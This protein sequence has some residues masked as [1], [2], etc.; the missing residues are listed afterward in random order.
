MKL[1][2]KIL[3]IFTFVFT[4][5]SIAYSHE[6]ELHSWNSG[7]HNSNFTGNMSKNAMEICDNQWG[8]SWLSTVYKNEIHDGAWD[9]DE[10]PQYIAHGY[11]PITGTTGGTFSGG[12]TTL[13]WAAEKWAEMESAFN[14]GQYI[15]GDG[16]G[17][18]HYLGRCCHLLQDMTT[19][20]HIHPQDITGLPYDLINPKHQAF[21]NSEL[22]AFKDTNWSAT[23]ALYLPTDSLDTIPKSTEKLDIFSADRLKSKTFTNNAIKSFIEQVARITYFRSTFWGEVLFATEDNDGSATSATTTSTTFSDGTVGSKDNI[24]HKMFGVGNIRYI[25]TWNND[26]FDITDQ[27]GGHFTWRSSSDGDDD[28]W[29]P[30]AEETQDGHFTS[31]GDPTDTGVRTTGRFHFT[32]AYNVNPLKYPD[33]STFTDSS[34][35]FYMCK[36]AIEVGLS[37]NAALIGVGSRKTQTISFQSQNPTSGVWIN[38][39]NHTNLQTIIYSTSGSGSYELGTV[40]TITAPTAVSGN[41][42]L[43]WLKNGSQ[44]STDQQ[45]IVGVKNNDTY[46]AVYTTGSSHEKYVYGGCVTSL[47]IGAD[48][49]WPSISPTTQFNYL[50]DPDHLCLR[51][52]LN[53]AYKNGDRDPAIRV[54]CKFYIPNDPEYSDAGEYYGYWYWVD[55]PPASGYYYAIDPFLILPGELNTASGGRFYFEDWPGRW[56][57][58]VYINEG[59]GRGNEL[60]EE[61]YFD[62]LAQ[63]VATPTFSPDGGSHASALNV[64][65]NCSTSNAI[66]HY[67]TDGTIPTESSSQYTGPISVNSSKTL[68]AKSWKHHWFPSAVKS[69]NYNI[70]ST[71]S[72]N[73]SGAPSV[74][75]SSST[76]HGGVTNYTKAEDIGTSV[77]LQAPYYVG[78]GVSRARFNGWIGSVTSSNQS[79]TFVMNGNKSVTANYISD[80]ETYVISGYVLTSE[81][82]GIIGVTVTANN[83]GT[84]YTTQADGFYTLTVPYNWTGRVTH[85]NKIWYEFTPEYSDYSNVITNQSQNYKG[86]YICGA[87]DGTESNPYEI[88]TAQQFNYIGKF[89]DLWSKHFNLMADIDMFIYSGTKYNII[90]NT[91]TPFTGSFDGNGHIISNLTISTSSSCI[92]LFGF[93][94]SGGQIKNLGLDNICISGGYATGGLVGWNSGIIMSCYATGSVT[95][96]SSV[97]G[98]VGYGYDDG[99]IMSCYAT[100]SVSGSYAVGGLV[101]DNDGII[102][103]CYAT[104]TVIS[105]ACVGGIVGG[106]NN[107]PTRSITISCFWDMQTSGQTVSASGRGL[108]TEQMKMMSIYQNAGWADKGWVMNDGVD[109]PRLSWEDSSGLP[110]PLPLAIPLVGNGTAEDPYLVSTPQ[111]FALLSWHSEVLDKHIRLT[112]DLDMSGITLYPIGDFGYFNGIFDGNSCILSNVAISQTSSDYV[113]LFGC[114]RYGGDVRDLIIKNIRI[115]GHDHVGGLAGW[116]SGTITNCIVSGTTTGFD[117][118]GGLVGY[119]D[120]GFITSCSTS[121]TVVGSDFYAGGLVGYNNYGTINACSAIGTVGNYSNGESCYVGGLV[122]QNNES[123]LAYCYATG[124]VTAASPYPPRIGGLVGYN[125]HSIID[126]CYATGLVSIISRCGCCSCIDTWQCCTPGGLI[127]YEFSS[128]VSACFWDFQ[129]SNQA[130]SAGGIGKTTAEMKN[131]STFTDAGWDFT[132]A[133]GDVADWMMLREGEDYPRLAWQSVI[134]GDVAGEYGI[135]LVDF[136][137]LTRW[138]KNSDCQLNQDCDHIDLNQD[139]TVDI[140]D[141]IIVA[142]NWLQGT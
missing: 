123:V 138:W 139:G 130:S 126:A 142:D 52:E 99:T 102:I 131:L 32:T 127:G 56:T 71:L 42:F 1:S 96:S 77:N 140:I 51:I 117:S 26:Y 110:I 43:K 59:E 132:A 128:I 20:A 103:S 101:G 15:G 86:T 5:F 48:F 53:D 49:P 22:A 106:N 97:G 124:N 90:G 133:D 7:D 108:I 85:S 4:L 65:I 11:N 137:Y 112:A 21:E 92:G 8:A 125:Y 113:G 63:T 76:G 50:G 83:G 81:G 58:K 37:Y 17:A 64:T 41:T 109:Y 78:S 121:V 79:I 116:N 118:V 36:Y 61:K 122:G 105:S 25:N 120:S 13:V 55:T 107:Y 115:I 119:N 57:Y 45:I 30:C 38:V 72:V 62:I 84:S 104:G 28:E 12:K 39:Y 89:P 73:S 95:G 23:L 10:F 9:E 100:C 135:D 40:L 129:T 29:F 75:I 60:I 82:S 19:Y 31:G 27:D 47:D 18:Y 74:N 68:R 93:L 67:T 98:L 88:S 80:P 134:P 136:S 141:L 66:I 54:E 14:S 6:T 69:A 35:G 114:I 2:H 46:T 94:R 3:A 111:E 16:V 44:Y 34:L 87:G 24:L 70:K 91:T 33:G